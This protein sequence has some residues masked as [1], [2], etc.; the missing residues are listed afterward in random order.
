MHVTV[1]HDISLDTISGLLS[2]AFEGGSNYWYTITEFGEPTKVEFRTA[3]SD[4]DKAS[5]E[6]VY[7]HIDYPLNPDGFLMIGDLEDE[8]RKP[9]KLN[10]VSIQAG[11]TIMA[12]KYPDH[13]AD[14]IKENDDATTG[15][16]FLQCCR[17]Y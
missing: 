9:L 15:D 16:V 12:E 7:R 2:S 4:S 14:I 17:N 6:I 13:F 10:L 3:I 1:K 8:E 5:T 11:L